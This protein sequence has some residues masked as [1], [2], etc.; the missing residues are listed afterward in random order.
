MARSDTAEERLAATLTWAQ[1]INEKLGRL[2]ATEGHRVHFRPGAKGIAMVG[3]LAERPQRGRSRVNDLDKVVDDFEAVFAQ[4]CQNI[5]EERVAPSDAVAS[6]LVRTSYPHERRMQA[7]ESAAEA[8]GDPLALTFVTDGIVLP[9]PTGKIA[10]GILAL[11]TDGGRS[12]PVLLQLC[13][14]RQTRQALYRVRTYA[15]LLDAHAEAFAAIF[16]ALLGR[17]VV[18]D[19]PAEKWIVWPAAVPGRDPQEG[20]IG[21]LGIRVVAYQPSETV[22]GAFELKVGGRVVT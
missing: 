12:T 16:G 11:R 2:L 21:G 8:S 18:F 4:F 10:S 1:R 13:D 19:G 6:F 22:A 15:A 7:L 14:D 9:I 17:T 3:L 5:V 20:E